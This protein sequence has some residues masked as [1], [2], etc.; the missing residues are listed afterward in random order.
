MQCYKNSTLVFRQN[1][2]FITTLRVASSDLFGARHPPSGTSHALTLGK[3][4]SAQYKGEK[5]KISEHLAYYKI[6]HQYSSINITERG[7]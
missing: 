4:M 2:Q 7:Y 3:Q 6:W 1:Y 5:A